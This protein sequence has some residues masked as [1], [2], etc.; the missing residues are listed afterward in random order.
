[1]RPADV[2]DH[3]ADL[4]ARLTSPVVYSAWRGQVEMDIRWEGSDPNYPGSRREQMNRAN[5][6]A[7]ITTLKTDLPEAECFYVNEDM[8]TL[9]QYA[10]TQLDETD[11]FR[12]LMLPSRSGIVRFEKGIPWQDVRG[13]KMILSWAVW[14]PILATDSRHD[15]GEPTEWTH[16]WL[17]NDHFDEPDQ[18]A[19]ELFTD[20]RERAVK[21]G[22]RPEEG[23]A[24]ARQTFGRWGFMGGEYLSENERLGPAMR[25]PDEEK[26]A[27]VLADGDTPTAYT[28]PKRVLHALWMLL[29]QTVTRTDDAHLDRPVR[30]RAMK[31]RIPARVTVVRLRNVETHR[32]PGESLVE[33]NH[34]WVVRGHPAWRACGPNHPQAELYPGTADKY[35][36][37]VWIAPFVKGPEDKPLIKNEKVYALVR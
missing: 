17:F 37:R 9:V 15:V 14:G 8:A 11:R 12:R 34:R 3:K 24:W 36:C 31:A 4:M 16:F 13:K 1:M 35:R 29:G 25:E 28:N 5:A 10:A 27:E 33:W 2:L 23:V 30:K 21:R 6:A 26:M 32:A 19:H 18:I 20:S 22:W 7:I